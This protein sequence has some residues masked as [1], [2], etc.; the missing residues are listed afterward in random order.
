MRIHQENSLTERHKK[1]AAIEC[2]PIT[3]GHRW[4]SGWEQV[5]RVQSF[6]RQGRSF[7]EH[8]E[9]K[10][11][12]SNRY[13]GLEISTKPTVQATAC[14]RVEMD[15][16]EELTGYRKSGIQESKLRWYYREGREAPE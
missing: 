15:R 10:H 16:P 12:V 8:R 6:H 4:K 13:T 2:E 14:C 3:L 7:R 9:S 11:G 1:R 5:P